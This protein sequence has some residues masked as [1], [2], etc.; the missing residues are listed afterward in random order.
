MTRWLSTLRLAGLGL[1]CGCTPLGLWEYQDPRLE[2]SRVR[3]YADPSTDSTVL[4]ALEVRNPN[5]YPLS[6]A[7]FELRLRLDDRTIGRYERDSVVSLPK[8]VTTTMMLAFTPTSGST[9]DRLSVLRAGT[10]HYRV[11]G[12]AIF[13]TPFG[14]QGIRV[15]H[16]GAMAFGRPGQ[17]E[18]D[19]VD[20]DAADASEFPPDPGPQ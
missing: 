13:T 11:E 15:A 2:V 17:P 1:L 10:H 14:E 3:V 4:V 8:V 7:R 19:P 12:R 18:S 5:D 9:V 20:E 16:S 6:T